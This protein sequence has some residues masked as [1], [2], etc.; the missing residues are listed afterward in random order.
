MPLSNGEKFRYFFQGIAGV[1]NQVSS[2][3][4]IDDITLTETACPSAVWQIKKFSEIFATATVGSS[5]SSGRFYNS[6]GYG[7]GFNVYPKGRDANSA[8]Y[9]GVTF[10]L[11]SGEND[12][13]LEWPAVNRQVTITAMDQDPDATLRM[14]NS[15]SFTTGG[16]TQHVHLY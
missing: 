11:Y 5:I 7:F 12:G 15:R 8:E 2:G 1:A 4:S 10:H 13:V 14:S 3:I 6:E 9:L 16:L